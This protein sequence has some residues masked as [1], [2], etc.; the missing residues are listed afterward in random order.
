MSVNRLEPLDQSATRKRRVDQIS[1]LLWLALGIIVIIQ[2]Y[3]LDY[4]AEYGPGPGFLPFWLGVGIIILGV[5]LLARAIFSG[6]GNDDFSFP[7]RHAAGQMFLVMVGLFGFVFLAEKV[8]FLLCIGLLFLFLLIVVERRGW[9]F[10]LAI[11][12]I[13]TLTFWIIFELE[14][15]LRLPPGLLE[16]LR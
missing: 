1:A 12:I 7:T 15:Q 9:K 5:A 3:E 14:L 11:A 10:S 6:K 4:M 8:G 16:L 2:S 13:S